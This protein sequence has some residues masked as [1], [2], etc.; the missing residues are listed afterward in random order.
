MEVKIVKKHSFRVIGKEGQGLSSEGEQWIPSLWKE[1]N[2][3]FNEIE[4]LAKKDSEGN[5]VGI[6]GVMTDINDNFNPWGKEGKYLAGCE[7]VDTA[8]APKNWTEWNIP[9]YKYIMASCA[10]K[11]YGKVFNY[12]LK[13]YMPENEYEL[14]GAVHE[15]YPQDSYDELFLY[16]PIEKI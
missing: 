7:V 1:A 6:W 2:E 15:F 11:T 16:F 4:S 8:V 5:I 13:E 14:V 12:I 9:G 10:Q 3:N